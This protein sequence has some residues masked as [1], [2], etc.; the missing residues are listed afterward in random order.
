MNICFTFLHRVMRTVLNDHGQYLSYLAVCNCLPYI[1][2]Y[3]K[4][5]Y[6]SFGLFVKGLYR[7]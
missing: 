6:Q 5:M 4:E 1:S 3:D 2:K 7:I